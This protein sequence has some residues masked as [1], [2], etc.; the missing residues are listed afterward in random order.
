MLTPHEAALGLI[1]TM[2]G[3]GSGRVRGADEDVIRRERLAFLDNAIS[4]VTRAIN[5]PARLLAREPS[6]D[7]LQAML[8]YISARR[9]ALSRD[10]ESAGVN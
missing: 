4:V 2:R 5:G 10:V 7:D 9:A 3:M 6:D 1:T 8:L